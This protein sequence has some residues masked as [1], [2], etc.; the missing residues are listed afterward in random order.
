MNSNDSL[1][2]KQRLLAL[3]SEVLD[4]LVAS[5]P[6]ESATNSTRL[7]TLDEA[8]EALKISKPTLRKRVRAGLIPAIQMG[9]ALR[10]DLPAVVAALKAKSPA[11]VRPEESI[12]VVR[13]ERRKVAS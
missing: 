9:D 7:S 12:G 11:A 6:G 8:C 2:C 1:R 10:F 3:F 4:L 5:E 13:C